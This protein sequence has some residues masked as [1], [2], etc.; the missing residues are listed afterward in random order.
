MKCIQ[1]PYFYDIRIPIAFS[2]GSSIDCL[3]RI[4]AV[5][6]WQVELFK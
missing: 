5:G 4:Q 1:I 3:A 6:K 2:N